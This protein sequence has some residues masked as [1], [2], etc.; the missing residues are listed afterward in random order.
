M[1]WGPSIC[2]G[3]TSGSIP[4]FPTSNQQVLRR[5]KTSPGPSDISLSRFQQACFAHVSNACPLM[6]SSVV[7]GIPSPKDPNNR[8]SKCVGAFLF[9]FCACPWAIML[10]GSGFRT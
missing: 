4:L 9:A 6:V 10:G 1:L 3:Y 5:G 7:E 8:C 2:K